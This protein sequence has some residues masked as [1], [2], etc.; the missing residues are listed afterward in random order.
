MRSLPLLLTA[1]IMA[2]SLSAASAQM[3][4]RTHLRNA[5]YGE[6]LLVKGGPFQFLGEVY[7]TLGLND[8]PEAAWKALDPAKIKKDFNARSVILNGPRYF[9]MDSNALANPGAVASFGPLEARHLASVK[10]SLIDVLRGKSKPYTGNTVNRTSRY[11]FKKGLPVYEL[12]SPEGKTYVMQSYSRIVDPRLSM[13][14]LPSLGKR[15]KLPKGWTYRER[16]PAEDL[17]LEAFG[18]AT[19]LQDELENSYQLVT[20]TH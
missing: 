7:N 11:I 14:D 8:C 6:I 1:L 13:S 10:I 3:R 5:R 4:E 20:A 15:L 16:I 2:A 18:T 19:V 17:V 9:L 12:I